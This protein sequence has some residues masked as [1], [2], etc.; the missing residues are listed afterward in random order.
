MT[1]PPPR[2]KHP[3]GCFAAGREVARALVLLSDGAFKLYIHLCLNADR[4]TGR[5]SSEYGRLAEASHKSR[6]S[7]VTY[8]EELR[9]HGVCSIQAAVNQHLGGQIEICDPF[10]PYE[11]VRL[12][13]KSDTLAGYIEQTRRLLSAKR[14]IGS[15]FTPADERLAAALFERRVPIEDV[16][17][18]VLLGCARKYVALINHQSRDSIVAFSYFQNVIEEVRELQMSAEYWNSSGPR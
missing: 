9:R 5:L 12:F 18:A 2:L 10:W 13:A 6:R 3:S 7:V 11:K 8:L 16:E 4:R 1:D 14:C 15:A 17:H